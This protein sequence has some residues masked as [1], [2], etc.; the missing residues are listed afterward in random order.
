[1]PPIHNFGLYLAMIRYSAVDIKLAKAHLGWEP[2]VA[3]EEGIEKTIAYFEHLLSRGGRY[4]SV[5]RK[6]LALVGGKARS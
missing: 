1:M 4:R 2:K 6:R 3:L 5:G